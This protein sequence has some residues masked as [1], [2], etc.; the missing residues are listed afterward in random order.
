MW[1]LNSIGN[2]V[3]AGAYNAYLNLFFKRGKKK[4][5]KDVKRIVCQEIVGCVCRGARK[6]RP[7]SS[8]CELLSGRCVGSLGRPCCIV[9][10]PLSLAWPAL[11]QSGSNKPW[12]KFP[13]F[14]S[15]LDSP[16]VLFADRKSLSLSPFLRAL[17]LAEMGHVTTLNHNNRAGSGLNDMFSSAL[18]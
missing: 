12:G 8:F 13:S 17:L 3:F 4:R 15:L 6:G 14:A 10:L 11:A 1:F 5:E 18:Q 16:V 2:A 9:R 7:S